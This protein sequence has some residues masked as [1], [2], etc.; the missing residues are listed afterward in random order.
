[1][2]LVG[3]AKLGKEMAEVSMELYGEVGFV[4]LPCIR[5]PCQQVAADGDA[6]PSLLVTML[7]SVKVNFISIQCIPP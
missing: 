3:A 4:R 1:M 6:V 7:M 5:R 2:P